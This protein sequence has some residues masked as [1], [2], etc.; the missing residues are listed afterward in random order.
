MP[1]SIERLALGVTG[2]SK[3]S[4]ARTR[5]QAALSTRPDL[6]GQQPRRLFQLLQVSVLRDIGQVHRHNPLGR[7]LP[8]LLDMAATDVQVPKIDHRPHMLVGHALDQL[9]ERLERVDKLKSHALAEVARCLKFKPKPDAV[10]P[11]D[12]AH[13]VKSPPM[14]F[15]V[16]V[17]GSFVTGRANRT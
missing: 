12:L 15:E 9:N 7:Q 2:P 3:P 8:D 4:S 11:E 14:E 5:R 10:R 6:L 17:V 1:W 16:L 13:L